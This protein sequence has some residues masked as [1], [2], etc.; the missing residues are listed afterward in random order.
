MRIW[1]H[2]LIHSLSITTHFISRSL[3]L[4][5]FSHRPRTFKSVLLNLQMLFPCYPRRCPCMSI[6]FPCYDISYLVATISIF[7]SALWCI[8]ACFVWLPPRL[9]SSEYSGE[10][11]GAGS[12]T[13]FFRATVFEFGSEQL[14]LEA[15]NENRMDCLGWAVEEVWEG[16]ETGRRSHHPH[17]HPHLNRRNSIGR[18]VEIRGEEMRRKL[19]LFPL[20][21]SLHPI[22]GNGILPSPPSQ[23][24]TCT[25]SVSSPVLRKC[26][27][28]PSSGYPASQLSL[29][30]TP[31]SARPSPKTSRAGFPKSSTV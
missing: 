10:I 12:I 11:A 30:S 5:P 3:R 15:V 23:H 6:Y 16:E 2:Q 13:A 4:D 28:Q 26:S 8:H 9:P 24:T 20:P 27:A 17:P 29:H 21:H 22:P 14:I 1:F 18:S 7:G 31:I 19:I 25:P